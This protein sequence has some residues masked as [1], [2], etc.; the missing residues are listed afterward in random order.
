MNI[1]I[2]YGTRHGWT[3]K[4]AENLDD[5]LRNQYNYKVEVTDYKISKEI[6]VNMPNYDLVIAGSSIVMGFWK[7]G[8]KRFLNKY[9]KHLR[10]VAIY[11]T[12]G[13]TLDDVTKGTLT[14]EEAI[15]KA[16]TKY[17]IPVKNKLGIST[18]ADGVFGGQYGK[19]PKILFNNWNKEDIKNWAAE[20]D[21]KLKK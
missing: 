1:L 15:Q 12:A 14:K 20:L 6:K 10:N 13:G 19:E 3:Q 4:T 21:K 5:I 16:K 17:I 11:V 7:R 9:K 8:V 18:I 2:V